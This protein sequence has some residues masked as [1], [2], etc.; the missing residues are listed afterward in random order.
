MYAW[1]AWNMSLLSSVNAVQLGLYVACFT[2]KFKV[3]K[4]Q[5]N[6]VFFDNVYVV[7]ACVCVWDTRG[8]GG[9][10]RFIS[11]AGNI[12]SVVCVKH[13]ASTCYLFV[14]TQG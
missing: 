4:T 13:V 7:C 9:E 11:F 12:K 8:T 14:N 2:N 10:L 5:H 3:E 6:H 1:K